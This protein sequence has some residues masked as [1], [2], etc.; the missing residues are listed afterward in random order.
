MKTAAAI[1]EILK[2]EG[3]DVLFGYPRNACWKQPR[4]PTSAPSSS[5][6]SASACTWRMPSRGSPAARRSAL[7]ACSTAPAP[8]TPM[9]ALRRHM[10]IPCRCSCCP[11]GYPRR[12]AHV[13]FNFNS[14]LQMA[15][16]SKHAEPVTVGAEVP[17]I[18]RR[19]FT[20]LRNGRP[21]PVVVEIP[22]D[23]FE[24]E[25]PEPLVYTPSIRDALRARIRRR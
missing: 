22:Y 8:R 20:Q 12:L 24:D 6:R 11:R 3:V 7:S 23:A 2:R 10:A 13:P 18:F 4:L 19:A 17:N 25:V 5:G 1:A 9:A 15:G 16:V 14:T 21:Q